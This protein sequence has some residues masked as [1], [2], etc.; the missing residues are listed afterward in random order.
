VTAVFDDQE[1][2]GVTSWGRCIRGHRLWRVRWRGRR[3]L[4]ATVCGPWD[5]EDAFL[6]AA[7][8]RERLTWVV[9]E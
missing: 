4:V 1:G 9:P 5:A 3:G 8:V 7:R 6:K 2:F